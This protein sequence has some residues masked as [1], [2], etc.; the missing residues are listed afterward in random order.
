MDIENVVMERAHR[1]GKK[2]KNG[3]RPIVVQFSFHKDKM[4]I[5]KNCKKLKNTRFSI[6]EDFSTETAAIRKEKWQEVLANR[7]K[8]M[9][10]YLNYRTFI[11]KQTVQ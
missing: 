11:C 3:S 10:S 7:E 2:N 5:L 6:F 4:K 8:G 9:I 1:T